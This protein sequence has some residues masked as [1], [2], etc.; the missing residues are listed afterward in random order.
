LSTLVSV[1]RDDQGRSLLAPGATAAIT[2]GQDL[3]AS[4]R[5]TRRPDTAILVS[6]QSLAPL[7]VAAT[8]APLRF[9]RANWNRPQTLSLRSLQDDV[10]DGDNLVPVRM[11]VAVAAK[12]HVQAFRQLWIDSLDSRVATSATPV[13]AT[14]RGS[15][16][17]GGT[18]GRVVGS[19]DSVTNRGTVTLRAT[20]P[21]L[22]N[23]RNR[24]I[25]VGYSLGTDNR[26]QIES[27]SGITASRFRWDV[28]YR[29]L[30]TDRGLFGTVTVLQPLLGRSA[31]ATL[32]AAAVPEAVQNL[33][34]AP[35]GAGSLLLS[36]NPPVGGATGYTVTIN[37][38]TTTT[39][40]T[41][42]STSMPFT[43]LSTT[44]PSYSFTVTATNAAGSGPAA[45]TSF[46]TPGDV[47]SQPLALS[48]TVAPGSGEAVLTWQPPADDGGSP[49]VSYTVTLYRRH[50]QQTV[51]TTSTSATFSGLASDAAPLLFR[52]RAI[53]FAGN[54]L[55]TSLAAAADGTPLPLPPSNPFMGLD[56]TST[57]HANA[58]SSDA[59]IFSGPGT[60]NLVLAHYNFDLDATVPSVLMSENGA[61]V[62]VGVGTTVST[63]QTPIVML[64]SPQ[65]LKPLDQVKLIKPQTGNLAGG[66]YNYLDHQNRLVL[67]DGD[68]VM[69]WYSN[70]YDQATDTG[71]L[72]LEK[73]VDIGQPM[74]VGLVP[75]Y[76]G[77]IWFAT[78]GS[79]ST[80][81]SPAVVGYYDPQTET[82]QTFNL[83]AGE[84]VANS[85]SSS[86]AGVAVTTTRGLALFAAGT[87]G[88]ITPLWHAVYENSGVRKPGQLSP[89][90][91]STP[92]FFGPTT[93]YE[94]LV[95]TDNATAP[96]TNNAIPA[97]NVNVYSVADGTLVAQT[98]FL[99]S[100]NAGT[101]NAPIAVGSRIFVPSTF[102]YWYPPPSET[103]AATPATAPFAGGFQGMTLAADGTNLTTNW[104]PANTVPSSAL[105]RLSLADN[106]IY[107]V[108]ATSTTQG[109]GTST[110]TTVSY[111]FAAV[112][113]DTG[114]IVGTPLAL[115]SNTFSGTSPDY[116]DT[117]SY[118]WNTL[119]MT[120]VISPD[121]VFYQGTAAGLVMVRRQQA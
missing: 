100:S 117:S 77:R 116:R 80:T 114:A 10:R 76:E 81:A 61:L 6:F 45:A 22:K 75:D 24:V 34:V 43:G 107:T 5:L 31:T 12:P 103:G 115:G 64:I 102:G 58:S 18:S 69:R 28:T 11:R 65:T 26:V 47:A 119:Q 50:G 17:G 66:L 99:T 49:V 97:E 30:G 27:L 7:E 110:Q 53:T 86:P 90:T 106:L 59:T 74:V 82:T 8:S 41:T 16:F 46:T 68:G 92:V 4:V 57:M 120:G 70:D 42:T 9:T 88:A 113:P 87:N 108:L 40:S 51:T 95:I 96:N 112:D 2:E 63:A 20:M 19:Y 94:Y 98:P 36:W 33:A 35:T 73:S 44:V 23:F 25:T 52:M 89:G 54:G 111:S 121:G 93:G 37:N 84:M 101:E 14:H 60:T 78:Q 15:V 83:P 1:V 32:T 72:T 29:E 105:P 62:C 13:T 104:G 55:P 79:L 118:S 21:Q 3:T 56:G 38:G 109:N 67:V 71:S 48:A 39:T 85:I 91:G